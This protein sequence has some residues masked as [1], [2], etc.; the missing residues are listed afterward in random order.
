M[1]VAGVQNGN[2][3][4]SVREVGNASASYEIG[5]TFNKDFA[6][7]ERLTIPLTLLILLGAFGALVAAGLPVLLA[8]SAVLASLGLYS[9]VTHASS[10]D[11][12]S[13]S[14]VIL[15]VGMAVGIDYSLFYLRREREERAAGQAPRAGAPA[16]SRHLRP[17]RA[18]LGHHGA[19]R[20]GRD[21]HRRQQDLHLDGVRDDARRPL[22]RRRLAH[23]PARSPLEARRPRR[24]R[25]HPLLRAQEARGRRVA[26]LGL[27]ARPRAA[28]AGH[29]RPARGRA[30]ARRR[31]PAPRDAH[32]AAELHRHAEGPA[33]RADLQGADHRVPG[34]TDAG[35][36]RRPGADV[37]ST[38]VAGRDPEPEAQRGRDRAD[39]PPI[40]VTLSPDNTV[41]DIQIPL[42]GQRRRHGV[43]GALATLRNVV[44]P[45]TIGRRRR[46]RSTP[47]QARRPGHT[48]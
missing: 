40:L 47:S 6:N 22:R 25:P 13:T 31:D 12:Q 48:T 23:G 21:V 27:R 36:R 29:G 32:E 41:A 42:A 2:P 4:V 43:A 39:V 34:R 16:R 5:K 14:A 10:G 9:L 45:Q 18:D 20:D 46:R 30:P 24:P 17:G 33:D 8:F 37:R 28:P 19:D 38:A 11:Y 1:A 35:R 44:L 26:L 7:A 3:S 15:L